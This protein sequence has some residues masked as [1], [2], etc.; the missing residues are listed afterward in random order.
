MSARSHIGKPLAGTEYLLE[1]W[2]IWRRVGRG[3]PSS[4]T[5][6]PSA[7][8]AVFHISDD[9]A[10]AVDGAVGR[11][12]ARSRKIGA[13]VLAYFGDGKAALRI[14]RENE[15]S[16]AKAR[17]LIAQG[18]AW[19]DCVLDHRAEHIDIRADDP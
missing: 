8:Q 17:E 5:T 6:G 18:V 1:Q 3:L 14:A 4:L 16:E 2:A 7:N 11:L 19:I 13:M 10:M 15:M 9:V 12:T